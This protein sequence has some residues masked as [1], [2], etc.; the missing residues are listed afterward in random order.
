[1]PIESMVDL[2]GG[3]AERYDLSK[4]EQQIIF[5]FIRRS[6]SAN[7]FITCSRKGKKL[8]FLNSLSFLLHTMHSVL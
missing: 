2:T 3:L 5:D 6:F 4:M 1:M 7:A 8:I